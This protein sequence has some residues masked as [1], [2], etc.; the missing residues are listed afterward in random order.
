MVTCELRDRISAVMTCDLRDS[1]SVV[2][3]FWRCLAFDT[4]QFWPGGVCAFSAPPVG[5]PSPKDT[6]CGQGLGP[7][8]H[9]FFPDCEQ[10]GYTGV[11]EVK[12]TWSFSVLSEEHEILRYLKK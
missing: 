5:V 6:I 12:D 7:P 3:I 10:S 2:M 8:V 11:R 1:G 9:S 4:A